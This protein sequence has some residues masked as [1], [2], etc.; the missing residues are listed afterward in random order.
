MSML[1][2]SPS[3]SCRVP[4]IPWT[5]S[6]L[7]EM[8]VVA[9]KGTVPGTPLNSGTALCSAKKRSITASISA[10]VTPGRIIAAANWCACQTNRPALRISAISRG[11]RRISTPDGSRRRAWR[12]RGSGVTNDEARMT[13]F[14]SDPRSVS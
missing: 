2:M 3:T 4:G 5:T 6:S 10:V 9:G 12:S 1:T 8:Q 13:N 7:T 11:E 14:P